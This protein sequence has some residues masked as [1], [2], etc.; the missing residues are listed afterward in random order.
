MVSISM[1]FS[2]LCLPLLTQYVVIDHKSK[3]MLSATQQR[4][5]SQHIPTHSHNS[6]IHSHSTMVKFFLL[7]SSHIFCSVLLMQLPRQKHSN[8]WH[9]ARN[10][11][12]TKETEQ[13][14]AVCQK[15]ISWGRRSTTTQLFQL[16]AQEREQDKTIAALEERL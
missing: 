14:L 4:L 3:K 11:F 12:L 13:N 16:K 6:Y 5:F 9:K 8:G 2:Y 15:S 1:A 10:A 7:V